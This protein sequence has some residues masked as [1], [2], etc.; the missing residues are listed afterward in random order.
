VVPADAVGTGAN[1]IVQLDS[2]AKLPA[3]DGSQLTNIPGNKLAVVTTNVSVDSTEKTVITATV[4]GG[5]LGTSNGIVG[6]FMLTAIDTDA[7]SR[8]YTVKLKYGAT[9][10]ATLV[11]TLQ[12]N[13]F[14]RKYP[15]MFEYVL[16]ASGATNTQEGNLFY[17]GVLN[18]GVGTGVPLAD[19]ATG[20]A[21]EDSTADK[22]FTVTIQT[23]NA[24]ATG[25]ITWAYAE[26]IK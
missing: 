22:T 25:S 16:L 20:T 15:V 10:V 21:A 26:Y 7:S 9:T 17:H 4:T 11:L 5:R 2:S 3:I 23:S 6:K 13:G 19:I 12:T 1:K 18:N 14:T 8:D 24:A